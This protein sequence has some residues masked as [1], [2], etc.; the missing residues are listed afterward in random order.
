[1]IG[2]SDEMIEELARKTGL[3]PQQIRAAYAGA[4]PNGQPIFN[5]PP[6]LLGGMQKTPGDRLQELQDAAN[7]ANEERYQQLLS[8]SDAHKSELTGFLTGQ[9]DKMMGYAGT[10]LDS[11]IERESR[12]KDELLGDMQGSLSSRGLGNTSI[13]DAFRLRAE[14]DSALRQAE[15]HGAADRQRLGIEGDYTSA[16]AGGL[17]DANRMRLGFIHDRT[18]QAPD[19]GLYAQMFSQP[20]GYL[21]PHGGGLYAGGGSASHAPS[22]FAGFDVDYNN[23]LRPPTGESYRNTATNPFQS[24]HGT[25][26]PPQTGPGPAQ[27][28]TRVTKSA[29]GSSTYASPGRVPQPGYIG[30]RP[31]GSVYHHPYGFALSGNTT[32]TFD[33]SHLKNQRRR[34]PH[35]PLYARVQ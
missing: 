23:A 3:S 28:P 5:L 31:S 16:Y 21:G 14:D 12:R 15:L 1:M 17:S 4:G 2:P 8:G 6:E 27:A 25:V 35:R 26:R 9:R 11:A 19:L 29:G 13:F 24:Y 34:P 22:G 18:D 7:K 10:W 30:S 32:P 33:Q 20:S